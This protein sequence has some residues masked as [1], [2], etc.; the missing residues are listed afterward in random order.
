MSVVPLITVRMGT[1]RMK[2][3][4]CI[5]DSSLQWGKDN[6]LLGR[7]LGLP[8]TLPSKGAVQFKKEVEN[9]NVEFSDKIKTSV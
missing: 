2:F 3:W 8:A 4:W 7:S 5:C 9:N 1:K 6:S